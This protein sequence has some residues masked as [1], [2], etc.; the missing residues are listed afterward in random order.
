MDEGWG[1]EGDK[2]KR[3][4]MIGDYENGGLKMAVVRLFARALKSTW[5]KKYIDTMQN[6]KYFSTYNCKIS[7][8]LP[9]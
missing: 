4:T 3:D 2:I 6:G 9:F 7:V 5:I 1:G 8:A